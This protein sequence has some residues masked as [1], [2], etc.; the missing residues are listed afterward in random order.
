MR[1]DRWFPL[2]GLA[3]FAATPPLAAQDARPNVLF[4]AVDDLRPTL[5]CYGHP[6]VQSPNIDRLAARGVLFDRAYCQFPLCNP[7]RSSL[8]TG[9]Y[10]ST[11]KVLDNSV[12]VAEALPDAVTLPAFFKDHGYVTARTGKIFHGGMDHQQVWT[13]GGEAGGTR[14]PRTP[15]QA[16]EYRQQS[17]RWVEVDGEGENLPDYRT[18]SQAVELLD[19]YNGEPFFLAVG[20]MKPHTSLI[21][22]AKYYE[23]YDAEAISLPATFAARP[24]VSEGAPEVALPKVNGD[25]FIDRDATPQEARE[26][27][28]AYFACTSWIDAQVGRVLDKLDELGL[29]ENTIIVFWGDHGFHLG[30]KGKWS[31]HNSLYE[32]ATRVPMIIVDPRGKV[33]GQASPRTVELVDLYPTLAELCGLAAPEGLEGQSLVPLL[34]NP[35]AEWTHPAITMTSKGQSIRT[36]RWRYT[37]WSGADGGAEFYDLTTDPDETKN[38]ANDPA[39]VRIVAELRDTLRQ[40][41]Q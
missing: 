4:I 3:L 25:I 35:E 28:R 23:L 9:R 15:A 32:P 41:L 2:V 31:K 14:K 12:Y 22:P 11:T 30:E 6:M 20:F 13:E 24:T 26:M 18:A 33:M 37:E 7:S 29:T 17:D 39:Y 19:K 34:Q 16:A 1:P 21:A 27:I 40:E 5:G 8:L 10:P 38:L 36:E